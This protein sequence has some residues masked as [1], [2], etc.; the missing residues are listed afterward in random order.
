ME[1]EITMARVMTKHAND[2]IE[3]MGVAKKW[4]LATDG[5]C[6]SY[7]SS[8]ISLITSAKSAMEKVAIAGNFHLVNIH[9]ELH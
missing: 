8:H 3:A 5:Q 4:W 6:Y 2:D 7:L 1:Q 9:I